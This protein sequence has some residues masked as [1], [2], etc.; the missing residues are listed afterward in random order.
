MWKDRKKLQ[1]A[2]IFLKIVTLIQTF[3][4]VLLS[5][6]VD[7][8]CHNR[9]LSEEDNINY[10]NI[11]RTRVLKFV[12]VLP[13]GASSLTLRFTHGEWPFS[14]VESSDKNKEATLMMHAFAQG[15]EETQERNMPGTVILD[16][17]FINY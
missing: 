1:I 5:Q 13:V 12:K 15:R 4:F 16:I 11:L 8:S 7:M 17:N 6:Y 10:R 14:I 3:I 2:I 9:L